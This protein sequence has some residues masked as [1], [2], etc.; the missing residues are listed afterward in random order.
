MNF[1]VNYN[2][3]ILEVGVT[4]FLAILGICP[5]TMNDIFVIASY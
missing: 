1:H 5:A 3:K 2:T 4:V